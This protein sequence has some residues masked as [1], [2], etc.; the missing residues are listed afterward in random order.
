MW[1]PSIAILSLAV[2]LWS[3]VYGFQRLQQRRVTT[4]EK[5]RS[6]LNSEVGWHHEQQHRNDIGY[7]FDS[8]QPA[9]L[10]RKRWLRACF[11]VGIISHFNGAVSP[12]VSAAAQPAIGS[13]QNDIIWLTGKDP[14]VP[15]KAP[16]DKNDV[17]GTK[18]DPDFLRSI[19]DCKNQCE[20]SAGPDGLARSKETCLSDCQDI[21]CRTYQ[22]CTFGIVPRI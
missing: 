19:A 4:L 14:V 21:C 1:V 11:S 5:L 12:E 3:P 17:K 18:R 2:T 8:S 20:N 22:Q 6:L 16:R 10:S 13:D 9:V 15:G 7:N